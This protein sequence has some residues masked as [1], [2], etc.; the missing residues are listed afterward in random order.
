M[1]LPMPPSQAQA[2]SY[3]NQ[4]VAGIIEVKHGDVAV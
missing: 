2:S 3:M 1:V 4:E